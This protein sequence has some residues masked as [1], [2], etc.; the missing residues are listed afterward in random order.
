MYIDCRVGMLYI[1]EEP[2]RRSYQGEYENEP[3]FIYSDWTANTDKRWDWGIFTMLSK[4][5]N[6]NGI[7]KI[8]MS[9]TLS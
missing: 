5:D 7:A 9:F 6:R 2:T 8:R 3:I 1:L 4:H